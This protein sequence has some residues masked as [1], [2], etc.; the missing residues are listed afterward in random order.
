MGARVYSG[1][2]VRLSRVDTVWGGGREA[3]RATRLPRKGLHAV[4]PG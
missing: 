1:D 2:L 4:V 3:G